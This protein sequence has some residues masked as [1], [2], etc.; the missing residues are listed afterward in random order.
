MMFNPVFPCTQ[1]GACCKALLTFETPL[2]HDETGRC[3]YLVDTVTP[4]GKPISV[5]SV[6]ETRADLGCPTLNSIKPTG[7]KWK[8]FYTMMRLGCINLQK[9][10]NMDSSY[11]PQISPELREDLTRLDES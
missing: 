3:D 10:L 4:E 6:Y 8:R 1:C 9:L 7:V 5:C 2:P 11:E